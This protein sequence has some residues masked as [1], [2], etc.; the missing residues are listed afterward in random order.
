MDTRNKTQYSLPLGPEIILYYVPSGRMVHYNI[1]PLYRYVG[2][3]YN[4]NINWQFMTTCTKE[5][6]LLLSRN[7][8]QPEVGSSWDYNQD[9]HKSW[10]SIW[11]QL[12]KGL[13]QYILN[14]PIKASE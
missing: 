5:L 10:I 12:F 8:E 9:D 6:N 13:L 7:Q 3:I 1:Q 11:L 14:C 4:V 2:G